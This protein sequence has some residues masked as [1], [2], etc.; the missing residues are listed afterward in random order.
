MAQPIAIASLPTRHAPD[1]H[2][3]SDAP[4]AEM[5]RGLWWSII[6]ITG[7]TSLGLNITHA[8]VY[9]H[10]GGDGLVEL[11]VTGR[12]ILA[13]IA[14]VLP[15]LMAGLLSHAFVVDAP[16]PIRLI[17]SGLFVLGMGMSLSAQVELLTPVIGGGRALGTAIVIDI[18]AL[19]SLFMIERC[20]RAEKAAERAA[21]ERLAAERRAAE[22]AR[23]DREE[24]ARQAE[25]R[26]AA[27]RL[28]V[29]E[30]AVEEAAARRAEAERQAAAARAAADRQAA[31]RAEAERAAA[32]ER[33]EAE[34]LAAERAAADR[35][36]AEAAAASERERAERLA[37]A[38]RLA[39]E[40]REAE[41]E[42]ALREQAQRREEE[43]RRE[44][45]RQ[46]RAARQ[47][48]RRAQAEQA[49]RGDLS[50]AQ[51]REIIAAAY[52]DNPAIKAPAAAAAVVSRGGQISEQR[53]RAVLA[54]IRQ[55][56]SAPLASVRPMRSFAAV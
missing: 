18:P 11:S 25:D 53:A 29:E 17:V 16:W 5:G 37:A 15:V 47:A 8:I 48:E 3:A 55:E 10:T 39:S 27:E 26:A 45:E 32:A 22:Q 46:A 7:A 30:R 44:T 1:P 23:R 51:K 20:N 4:A 12:A 19:I 2:E 33:V 54:E 6:V 49:Q 14:S 52:A 43:A 28:A 9:K 42:R 24:A 13:V 38:A 56:T 21:A 40:Q 41:R 50:P 35:Q 31:E 34:R 36:A